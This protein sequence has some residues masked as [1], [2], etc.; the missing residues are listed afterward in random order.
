MLTVNSVADVYQFKQ[1]RLLFLI[2]ILKDFV[3]DC[4]FHVVPIYQDSLL[5]KEVEGM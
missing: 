5:V 2:K 4:Q 3:I 1:L